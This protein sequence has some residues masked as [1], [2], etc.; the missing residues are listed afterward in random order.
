MELLTKL[1]TSGDSLLQLFAND[2]GMLIEFLFIMTF[3]VSV[4]TEI[5]KSF[6]FLSKVPTDAYVLVL[7]MILTV[8]YYVIY[9]TIYSL[10]ITWYELIIFIIIGFFVAYVAMYGWSKLSDIYNRLQPKQ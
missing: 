9:N 5:T 4:I 10:T 7:S 6:S 3:V 8:L 1:F 2:I